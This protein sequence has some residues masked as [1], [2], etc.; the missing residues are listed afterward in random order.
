MGVYLHTGEFSAEWVIQWQQS[1]GYSGVI[2]SYEVTGEPAVQALYFFSVAILPPLVEEFFFR[3]VI[4]RMFRWFGD[5]FAVVASA[6][7][8]ASLPWEYGAVPLCVDLRVSIG[9]P[10][11]KDQQYMGAHRV[12]FVNN[13]ISCMWSMLAVTAG[14]SAANAFS[15]WA[16]IAILVLGLFSLILLIFKKRRFFS[17]P[18]TEH[19]FVP[20]TRA[21]ISS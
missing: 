7:L 20:G 15:S 17:L 8:F 4:L 5:G 2:P 11:G 6:V 16:T 10:D 3:G 14:T 18:K 1:M 12:H 21:L 13:G 19:I 9:I